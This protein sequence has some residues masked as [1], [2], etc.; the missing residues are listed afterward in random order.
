MTGNGGLDRTGHDMCWSIR[1]TGTICYRSK[2]FRT[3]FNSE[4]EDAETGEVNLE[5]S[6]GPALLP[7]VEGLYSHEV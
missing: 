1:D 6:Y 3:K 2:F 4:F 7:L 5:D